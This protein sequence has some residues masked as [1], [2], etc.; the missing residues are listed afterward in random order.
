MSRGLFPV[1]SDIVVPWRD[2]DVM[3]AHGAKRALSEPRRP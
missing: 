1:A 3:Y 2:K